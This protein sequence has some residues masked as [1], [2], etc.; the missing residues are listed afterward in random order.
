MPSNQGEGQNCSAKVQVEKYPFILHTI[1][2]VHDLLYDIEVT[3]REGEIDMV[4]IH[5]QPFHEARVQ[6]KCLRKEKV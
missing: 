6:Q 2:Y 5:L 3:K 4:G 1:Q